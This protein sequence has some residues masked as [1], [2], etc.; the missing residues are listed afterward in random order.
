MAA[1]LKRC[2]TCHFGLI[3]QGDFTKRLCYGAPP[4]AI[5][6]PAPGGRTTVQSARPFVSITDLACALYRDKDMI[7]KQRDETDLRRGP[8]VPNDPPPMK[9]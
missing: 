2:G 1:E 3:V 7:D 5:Q 6:M 9:Q 8:V 4:S